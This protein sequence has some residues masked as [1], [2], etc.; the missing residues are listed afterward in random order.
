MDSYYH[1][2]KPPLFSKGDKQMKK[3]TN[4]VRIL[5]LAGMIAIITPAITIAADEISSLENEILTQGNAALESMSANLAHNMNWNEQVSKQLARQLAEQAFS[6][7]TAA[8]AECTQGLLPA[9]EKKSLSVKPLQS[10]QPG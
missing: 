7:E 5:V 2:Q 9:D 10:G 3:I 6:P 1:R 4:T 8:A